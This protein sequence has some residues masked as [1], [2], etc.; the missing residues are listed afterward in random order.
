M[1]T[2]IIGWLAIAGVLLLTGTAE[3]QDKK[4][5][6]ER[7]RIT[8]EELVETAERF[9]DLY[10]AI[11]SLRAHFLAPNNRGT[12]TTGVGERSA[13]SSSSSGGSYGSGGSNAANALAVVYIDGRRSGDP[14]VIKGLKTTEFEEIRYLTAN[15]AGQEY[16]L[17]HEGGAILIKTW[18][19]KKP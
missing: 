7:N 11:R 17:G 1:T 6:R 13:E 5:K 4:V 8:R 3:A 19:E 16:G 15:E 14:N 10:D 18:Q 12:R 2:R 9:P